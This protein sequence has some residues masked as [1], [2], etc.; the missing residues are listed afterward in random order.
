MLEVTYTKS[1]NENL[2]TL[3]YLY[4]RFICKFSHKVHLPSTIKSNIKSKANKSETVSK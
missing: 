2:I 4:E 3:R 1:R